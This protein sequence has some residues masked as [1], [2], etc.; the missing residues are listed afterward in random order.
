VGATS[1]GFD[2][3]TFEEYIVTIL[4]MVDAVGI[5][6]VAIGTD[7]DFT[8]KPVFSD[9]RDWSLVPAALLAHGMHDAEVAKILGG[10][11]LRL[12]DAARDGSVA[13]QTAGACGKATRDGSKLNGI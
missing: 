9:Y 8:F 1:A 10:N 13:R 4:R 3:S 12:L 6:H 5:D 11:F 2:Q 7:L